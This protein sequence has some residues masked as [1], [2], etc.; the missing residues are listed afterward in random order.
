MCPNKK[1]R[2]ESILAYWEERADENPDSPAATTDD[3][4]LRELEILTLT[5]TLKGLLRQRP[6][7]LLEVGCGDGYSTLRIASA[8]P[9][10][11]IT[12]V[13]FS[14]NMIRNANL[15]LSKE[16][17][18]R[19]RL[20]FLIGDV[21]DLH[22]VVG[23]NQYDLVLS[24]RCLINLASL[25]EQEQALQKIAEHLSPEGFFIA[26]ENFVEGQE[27][28]NEARK[29][30]GLDEIPV[31]W[32]NLY[33]REDEFRSMVGKFAKTIEFRDFSSSYYFA[34]RVIYSAMCRIRGEEPDYLH[35]IHRRAVELP[36]TG[37]FSPIRMAIVEK[38]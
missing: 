25:K 37:A 8:L 29:I 19:K 17:D 15:R 4:Y 10:L 30:M 28:M 9:N 16:S 14:R 13:D 20:K 1:R 11:Q 5:D 7:S 12:A 6:G 34:T 22:P 23:E 27:R 35:E 21:R 24:D 2:R 31:R 38:G 18:L 36:W 32:H 3:I 26:I 33:F